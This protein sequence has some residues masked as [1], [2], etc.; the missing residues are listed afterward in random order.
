MSNLSELFPI[1]VSTHNLYFHEEASIFSLDSFDDSVATGGGDGVVRLWKLQLDE[2]THLDYK[3]TT[4][5]NSSIKFIYKSDIIVHNKAVNCVRFNKQGILASSSDSG[6]VIINY[7]KTKVLRDSDGLD[8]YEIM[9]IDDKLLVGLSNGKIE[10]YYVDRE[11]VERSKMV[12]TYSVHGDIIQGMSYNEKYKLIMTFSKDRTSKILDY[13]LKEEKKAKAPTKDTVGE[14]TQK[15]SKKMDTVGATTQSTE[16]KACAKKQLT[17]SKKTD[18]KNVSGQSASKEVSKSIDT[19]ED[20][21]QTKTPKNV[22]SANV[23][24]LK[25]TKLKPKK[26]DIL[27]TFSLNSSG[28]SFFRRGSF[29]TSGLMAYIP[30]SKHNSL[31]VLNFPFTESYWAYQMGPF[32]SEVIRVLDNEKY[33]FILCKTSLY[34]YKDFVLLSCIE[35]ITFKSVTDAT[36]IGNV[37]LITALDGF[38]ASF[39]YN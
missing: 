28:R 35:N 32:N 12:K 29:S 19:N 10:E 7:N 22:E 25:N 34:I 20:A 17:K 33:L 13:E 24:S 36:L 5:L 6:K 8:C 4:A 27:E 38:I 11:D 2:M 9:W 21:A 15:T 16:R 18:T 3:Y 37:L 1:E 39:R 26:L 14:T 31:S 30:N 23:T